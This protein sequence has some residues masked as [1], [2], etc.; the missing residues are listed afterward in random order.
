MRPPAASPPPRRPDATT[1]SAHKFA[2]WVPSWSV[3][4]STAAE[5]EA[6]GGRYSPAYYLRDLPGPAHPEERRRRGVTHARSRGTRC[7]AVG[8]VGATR[9]RRFKTIGHLPVY[10]DRSRANDA[11]RHRR[12]IYRWSNGQR[13]TARGRHVLP[14]ASAS[15]I[16]RP[17]PVARTVSGRA[18]V[19]SFVCLDVEP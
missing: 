5:A 2:R 18:F 3:A 10:I 1:V 12:S 15:V 17:R 7:P 13:M 8:A 6:P 14:V 9:A 11:P 4:R 16:C 19:R